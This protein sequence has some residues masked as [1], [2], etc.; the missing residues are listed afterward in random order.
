MSECTCPWK[1][2]GL[3]EDTIK[4][5]RVK[6]DVLCPVHGAE[7]TLENRALL[8]DPN[9]SDKEI[10]QILGKKD[11]ECCCPPTGVFAMCPVH[12]LKR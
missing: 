6:T 7:P 1:R 10:V 9:L 4:F 12:G 11:P 8:G 3:T 2:S 5:D